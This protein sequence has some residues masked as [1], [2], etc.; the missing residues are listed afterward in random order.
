MS[1]LDKLN[2][3]PGKIIKSSLLE[4]KVLSFDENS[5]E[6]EVISNP[7]SFMQRYIDV[8]KKY[9]LFRHEHWNGDLLLWEIPGKQMKRDFSQVLLQWEK[10]IGWTWDL[11]S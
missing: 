1:I 4:A 3:F 9:K 2:L 8:G 10:D 11:D 6:I 7:T 5:I